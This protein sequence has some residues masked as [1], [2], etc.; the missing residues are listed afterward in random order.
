MKI[1]Q[2]NLNKAIKA[3]RQCSKE[4]KNNFTDTGKIR[5]SDLC[6]D[7]ADFLEEEYKN[8]I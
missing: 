1:T 4:N 8:Q 2:K 6:D 5:I 3:L 7:V